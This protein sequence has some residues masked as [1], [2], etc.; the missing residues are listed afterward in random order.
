LRAE[1]AA[2]VLPHVGVVVGPYDP[3]EG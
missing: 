1:E 2:D 3:R